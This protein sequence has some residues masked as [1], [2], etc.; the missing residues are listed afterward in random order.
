MRAHALLVLLAAAIAANAAA[1]ATDV[2]TA[3][4]WTERGVVPPVHTQGQ[5]GA[6]WV[7]PTLDTLTAAVTIRRGGPLQAL[8]EQELE[9]CLTGRNVMPYDG[10]E[11]AVKHGMCSE[12]AYPPGPS[13]GCRA[14]SCS[15]VAR[16]GNAT[17]V[18]SNNAAAMI[19]ALQVGPIAVLVNAA[20][21]MTYEGGIFKG[22]C[23]PTLDHVALLVGYT[24]EAWIVKNSWGSDWGEHGYIRLAR[25][26]GG[27]KGQCGVLVQG[28]YV[29]SV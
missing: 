27:S 1:V 11:W 3:L 21:W 24:P 4:N 22:S 6:S 23:P 28:A 2:P 26:I 8:S 5:L 16:F 17:R 29:I 20:P 15:P 10:F 18:T 9:D 19:A 13:E 12:A 7:W 25:N 14:G